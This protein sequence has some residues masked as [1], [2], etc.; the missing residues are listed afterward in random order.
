MSWLDAL[1]ALSK[2]VAQQPTKK[3]ASKPTEPPVARKPWRGETTAPT[4]PIAPPLVPEA[5]KPPPKV[6][7]VFFDVEHARPDRGDPGR[8]EQVFYS[9][10]GTTLSIHHDASGERTVA[11]RQ[12]G[13]EECPKQVAARIGKQAWLRSDGPSSEFNRPLRWPK[14]GIA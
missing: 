14:P 2:R 8:V 13:P 4:R 1:D 3:A 10:D 7:T 5:P 9:T 11:T 12:L 6:F